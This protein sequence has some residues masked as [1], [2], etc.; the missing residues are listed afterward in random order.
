MIESGEYNVQTDNAYQVWT[1]S[2]YAT[3]YSNAVVQIK[4]GDEIFSVFPMM[5]GM[6]GRLVIEHG[7]DFSMYTDDSGMQDDVMIAYGLLTRCYN[8]QILV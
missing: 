3:M 6:D 2:R 8:I 1:A 4:N 7:Y 5:L